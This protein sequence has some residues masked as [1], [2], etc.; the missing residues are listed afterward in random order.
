MKNTIDTTGD[1]TR[2][3]PACSKVSQPTASPRG[4]HTLV[5]DIKT[6][7]KEMGCGGM[8]WIKLAGGRDRW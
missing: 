7:S 6:S 2:Y 8:D 1:L 3:H 5:V 4:P